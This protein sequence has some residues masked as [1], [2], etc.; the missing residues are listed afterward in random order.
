MLLVRIM[1]IL[2]SLVSSVLADKVALVAPDKLVPFAV[3]LDILE[4]ACD[5]S[6]STVRLHLAAEAE[7]LEFMAHNAAVFDQVAFKHADFTLQIENV[8]VKVVLAIVK[9]TA[10]LEHSCAVQIVSELKL[11]HCVQF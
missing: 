6:Q 3:W 7:I 8:A 9:V 4:R 5:V 10:R 2:V 1:D 11:V